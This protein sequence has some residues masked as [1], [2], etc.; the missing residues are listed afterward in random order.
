M[1]FSPRRLQPDD[2]ATRDEERDENERNGRKHRTSTAIIWP[3]IERLFI[4]QRSGTTRGQ[5]RQQ[6]EPSQKIDPRSANDRRA[7]L[8]LTAAPF[9]FFAVVRLVPGMPLEAK[10]LGKQ[11][12]GW[13]SNPHGLAAT[14]F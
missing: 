14:G 8:C 6:R 9:R 3:A 7:R 10:T 12:R 11:C 1:T 2:D 5:G 13:G 4:D